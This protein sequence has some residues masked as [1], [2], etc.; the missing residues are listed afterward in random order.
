MKAKPKRPAAPATTA[1]AAAPA[2]A[3]P[4]KARLGFIGAGWWSTTQYMPLLR[5]RPDVEF[6]SVCG[7]DE[8]VLQRC[9]Q[10]FG[11]THTT[12]DYRDLLRQDLDGVI[13]GSPHALHATHARAA[14]SAGCHVMVEKPFTTRSADAHELVRL[15]KRK[16]RHLLVPCG[17]QYRP[18]GVEAKKRMEQGVV[19]PIEFV[20]CHMASPLRNLFSGKAFDFAAGAYVSANLSTWADPKHSHGGYGQGQ[21]SHAIGLLLWLTGLRPKTV[22]ARMSAPGS[23]VDMYD[24]MSVTW[25]GGAVGTVSGSATLPPGTPCG[26]QLDLKIFGAKGMLHLDISRDYLAWYGHDGRHETVPLQPGDGGYQCDLPPQQ[27]VDL[28]LDRTAANNSP[29][30]AAMH[31]VD[32]LDAAYRS[33]RSGQVETASAKK[34]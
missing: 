4:R 6:V 25:H 15:A 20:T 33:S 1:P 2:P 19:G 11:F 26:F 3:M 29:G 17:W 12:T 22:Y 23:R 18:I 5:A 27:F 14:L 24:A 28:V 9:R 8:K 10:D 13:V 34:R 7:L 21:L 31:A 16:K 32:L 30:E